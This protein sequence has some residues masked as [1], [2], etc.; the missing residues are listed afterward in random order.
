MDDQPGLRI[1]G[2]LPRDG[3]PP[4]SV[5]DLTVRVARSFDRSD[6]AVPR[7]RL[8]T[9]IAGKVLETSQ[10]V[11]SIDASQDERFDGMASVEDLQ[12][13]SVMC[14]PIEVEER[15]LG[16]LYVDNRLQHNAFNA[17]DIELVEL[18]AAQAGATEVHA[19]ECSEI[20]DQAREVARLK[21]M[22]PTAAAL[23]ASRWWPMVRSRASRPG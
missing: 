21:A 16:V 12:L 3:E 1:D 10:A 5:N 23:A 7:S 14:L 20:V 13:R 11:L 9:G 6:I 18:F 17:E 15:V 2:R 19:I 4:P 8:S 22:S